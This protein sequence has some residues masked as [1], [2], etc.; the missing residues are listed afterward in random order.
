[1]VGCVNVRTAYPCLWTR[2]AMGVFEGL[3]RRTFAHDG[4][5]GKTQ[6][7]TSLYVVGCLL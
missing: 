7:I 1:M 4:A 3:V 2:S 6:M 5:R